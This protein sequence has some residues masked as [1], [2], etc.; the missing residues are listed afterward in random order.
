MK[1]I[2]E[3]LQSVGV[4]DPATRAELAGQ[5]QAYAFNLAVH[6]LAASTALTAADQAAIKRVVD[7]G[8]L[9]KAALDQ[10][11]PDQPRRQIFQAALTDALKLVVEPEPNTV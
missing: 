6:N 5:I 10:L 7:T 2:D 9:D 1:T 3:L 8:Q 11:F 4:T